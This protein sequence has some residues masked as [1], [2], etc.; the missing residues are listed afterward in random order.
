VAGGFSRRRGLV[1]GLAT[2]I[3]L[4]IAIAPAGASALELQQVGSFDRPTYVTS[5]P[6]DPNR[7]FVVEQPGRIKL[8]EGASTMTFLD[9]EPLVHDLNTRGDYGLLSMAFS[10]EYAND[11]LFYLLYTNLD[12]DWQIDEFSANGDSAD[13][14][15]RRAVL[16]VKY[17]PPAN[18]PFCSPQ[19]HYGGQLQFGPDGY[20]YAS[21]GDGGP[22]GDPDGNAQHLQTLLGKIL[23]IDPEGSAPGEY[24]VPADNPF[25]TDG[26]TDGCDEIWSYGLR[27]PWRFSF[28]RLTRNLVIGD[29]GHQSW[30]EV[31]FEP[32][33]DPGRGANFGW[34]CR[35]GAHPGPGQSSAVCAA[36]TGAFTEPFFEYP[37]VLDVNAS[38]SDPAAPRLVGSITGGYVVRDRALADLYGR[39]LYADFCVGELR[40]LVLGLP[41]T[42]D[43]RSE[44]LSVPFPSSF[45]EDADCRIYVAS[46]N[47]PIYRLAEPA[48][49]TAVG[50]PPPETSIDSG[51][52]EDSITND[53]TPTFEFSSSEPDSRFECQVDGGGFFACTSPYT[54]DPL[55]DG[56]RTFAVRAI[57]RTGKPDPT[58]ASRTI[59]VDATPRA[60]AA[61]CRGKRATIVGTRGAEQIT[62]TPGADVIVGLGGNDELSGLAGNDVICGGKGKDALSGQNGN[63]KLS[64]EAGNDTL[65]GAAGK[66]ILKG[67]PGNDVLKGGPGRDVLK[68]GTGRDKQVQ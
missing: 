3:V 7:L 38:C 1:I 15:S 44:G 23:R 6:Q 21:T 58:P 64:G 19:C 30:E 18:N 61:A 27:N 39:Y 16:S 37:H 20:L 52:A 14:A 43:D 53:N 49:G 5:D 13:P 59:T 26:C 50:C 45:G 56:D 40:S 28:D 8:I 17:P 42:S 12:G 66:D 35:E 9:I 67:G 4:L 46:L 55:P 32:G 41:T 25:N 48:A 65:A 47:G 33:P 10:P 54:T 63:D 62:G 2:A 57:S 11:H 36:R 51:P 24:T 60:P 34:N 22:Q 31:D 68:G 29:V